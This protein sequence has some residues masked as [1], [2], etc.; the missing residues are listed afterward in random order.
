M[1][2]SYLTSLLVCFAIAAFPTISLAGLSDGL[3]GHWEFEDNFEDSSSENNDGAAMNGATFTHGKLGRGLSL[4][5]QNDMV[6]VPYDVSLAPGEGDFSVSAWFL[7]DATG[8]TKMRIVDSRG[9]G[10]SGETVGWQIIIRQTTSGDG[11]YFQATGLDDASTN[12]RISDGRGKNYPYGEW[13]H[14][15]MVY[16]ADWEARL[17]INGRLD[18]IIDVYGSYGDLTSGLPLAIGGALAYEGV[19]D[20]QL[21]NGGAHNT[22]K[23]R[24]D[25]VRVYDRA[26]AEDEVDKLYLE[27]GTGPFIVRDLTLHVPDDHAT[28]QD[29]FDYLN[30]RTIQG[31]A[32]ATIQVEDGTYTNYD[33]IDVTHPQGK[34]IYLLGNTSDA[35]QVEI[36]FNENH[37]GVRLK[38][39]RDL[40][41]L[42]GFT[43]KGTN[44]TGNGL[45]VLW[46][47]SLTCGPQM[48][49][50]D[51]DKGLRAVNSSF[52]FADHLV[53]KSNGSHGLVCDSGSSLV[54]RYVTTE[55]NGGHGLTTSYG[56]T[57]LFDHSTSKD[58]TGYGINAV[59]NGTVRA[60]TT[61]LTNN[62]AGATNEDGV[63]A[64]SW[65]QP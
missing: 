19:E 11:F 8:Q 31:A 42:D 21:P 45:E 33:T 2:R 63:S 20:Q 56:S 1:K 6:R 34:Q 7:P 23:G 17:Y 28:I 24:I 48:V 25:E 4:D 52:V 40:G 15:A 43:L 47:S 36:T 32:I 64:I 12:M 9:S 60:L 29:A 46:K 65:T 55:D 54:A 26:I 5:G 39:G 13:Y 18:S 41:K 62:T 10:T 49:V 14:V 30:E 37:N 44:H 16:N 58:N 27:G 51:F 35:S 3:V 38:D 50:Q 59:F 61:T 53:S 22:F 57:T